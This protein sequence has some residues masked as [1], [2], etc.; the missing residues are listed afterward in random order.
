MEESFQ[1]SGGR[2]EN[3]LRVALF[4]RFVCLPRGERAS[5]RLFLIGG[6]LSSGIVTP[7]S[8]T[9]HVVCIVTVGTICYIRCIA[10]VLA[11]I[12]VIMATDAAA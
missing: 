11:A 7:V 8:C 10:I 4:T 12:I 9:V 2:S 3:L 1:P 6:F 5:G